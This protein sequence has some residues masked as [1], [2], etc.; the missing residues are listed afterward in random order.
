MSEARR[1]LVVDDDRA[2]RELVKKLMVRQGFIID[3]A[4]DG[5]DA[6]LLIAGNLYDAVLL[7]L[8]MPNLNGF[9]LVDRLRRDKPSLLPRIVIMTAF[10]RA[11]KI[12]IVEGVHSVLRKPFD[13]GE[14]LEH[15]TAVVGEKK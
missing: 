9:D 13:I 8:M 14:L 3:T 1:L 10:S 12:P 4:A 5:Q 7:D 15:V 2:I 11:G 6:W